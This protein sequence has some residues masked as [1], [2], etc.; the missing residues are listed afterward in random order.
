MVRLRHFLTVPVPSLQYLFQHVHLVFCLVTF[1]KEIMMKTI[2]LL[3]LGMKIPYCIYMCTFIITYIL[4][5][6]YVSSHSL[7]I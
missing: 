3:P 1:N 2:S 6:P 7:F 5:H 4:H